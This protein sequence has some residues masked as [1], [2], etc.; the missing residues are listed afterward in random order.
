[1]S[2]KTHTHI[3]GPFTRSHFA[4]T[5]RRECQIPG[6]RVVSLDSDDDVDDSEEDEHP[7][8]TERKRLMLGL[9]SRKGQ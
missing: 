3:F 5:W 8:I 7:Y 1:M 2:V 9:S 6:C 4:G